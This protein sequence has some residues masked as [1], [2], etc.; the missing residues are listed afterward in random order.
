VRLLDKLEPILLI[1]AVGLGLFLSRFPDISPYASKL[2]SPF[3]TVMLFGLFWEAPLKDLGKSFAKYRFT[4]V[5]IIINFIWTPIFAWLLTEIFMPHNALLGLGFFL[6]LITP[7]TDWFLVFTG[8]AKGNVPLSLAILPLNLF[9]QIIL[10]PFY[11]FAFSGSWGGANVLLLAKSAVIVLL[12]PLA[13]SKILKFALKGLGPVARALEKTVVKR[14]FLWLW[15]AIAAMFASERIIE[16]GK[17]GVFIQILAPT[18]TFFIVTFFLAHVV[19]RTL[20]Y[21]YEDYVSLAFTTLARNSP[22]S[23]AFAQQAF[24]DDRLVLLPLVVGPLVELPVLALIAQLLL[25]YW[26]RVVKP[27][28]NRDRRKGR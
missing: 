11:I 14:Q 24:P 12:I 4:V 23:I 15:L 8:V 21:S 1:L 25:M 16:P 6:L 22:L 7:C 18:L 19:A 3:L 2:V 20:F 9:L 17:L 28:L 26:A 27:K 13:V 10:M 5:A